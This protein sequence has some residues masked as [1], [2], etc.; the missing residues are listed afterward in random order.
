[1]INIKNIISTDKLISVKVQRF[2]GNNPDRIVANEIVRRQYN[3]P[4]YWE[5]DDLDIV[6][7][8]KAPLIDVN[9]EGY[10]E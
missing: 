3:I 6:T 8:K 4:S 1:M 2:A 9:K 5:E 10:G 7:I